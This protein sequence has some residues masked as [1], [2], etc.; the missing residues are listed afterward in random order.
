MPCKSRGDEPAYDP[1][2]KSGLV[3]QY[4]PFIKKWVGKFLKQ[5]PR[6]DRQDVMFRAVERAHAAERTF[7]APTSLRSA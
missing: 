7:T 1:F 2:P 4:E 3:K 5:Y 6:L